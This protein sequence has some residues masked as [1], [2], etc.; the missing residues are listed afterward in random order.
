MERDNGLILAELNHV[1]KN[2]EQCEKEN[3]TI[4]KE[5]DEILDRMLQEKMNTMDQLN[6]MNNLVEQK[7]LMIE[8][9]KNQMKQLQKELHINNYEGG[10][11]GRPGQQQSFDMQRTNENLSINVMD[12]GD[13]YFSANMVGTRLPTECRL[14]KC[15]ENDINDIYHDDTSKTIISAGSDSCV[16]LWEAGNTYAIGTCHGRLPNQAF[17]R[18]DTKE[19]LVAAG[20]SSNEIRI[21]NMKS[22]RMKFDLIGHQNMVSALK[23]SADAKTLVSGSNDRTLKIWDI[24]KQRATAMKTL[25][26]G[27][28]CNSLDLSLEATSAIS[29]HQ[30]GCIRQWDLRSGQQS[31][32]VKDIFTSAAT[33]V[34]YIHGVSILVNSKDHAL[35][36]IDTRTYE[37]VTVFK[38]KNYRTTQNWSRVSV[39]PNGQY[40]CAGS[41][42]GSLFIWLTDTG[43]LVKELTGHTAPIVGVSWAQ[44]AIIEQQIVS[45]DQ[46]GNVGFWI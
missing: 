2:L 7:N 21:W 10:P 11:G 1:R 5:R 41:S 34:S 38:H 22:Q 45:C 36:L 14:S 24:S 18:V 25:R 20:T 12:D 6:E 28:T 9:L 19:N 33:Y 17:L 31:A 29:A 4:K 13:D 27:S 40:V 23:F 16:K 30:D 26:S 43:H 3:I 15:H 46:E 39:S 35:K 8:N 37:V 44:N 32:I 42:S